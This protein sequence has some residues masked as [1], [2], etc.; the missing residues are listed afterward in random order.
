MWARC[1]DVD[2]WPTW[3]TLVRAVDA[4]GPFAP[5]LEAELVLAGGVRVA[6]EI[7]GADE[8]GPSWTRRLRLGRLRIEVEHHVD[9]GFGLVVITASPA[10]ALVYAPFARRSLTNLLRGR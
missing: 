5:G 1:R 9:D 3:M 6:L 8:A 7:V 4:G 10:I 2:R